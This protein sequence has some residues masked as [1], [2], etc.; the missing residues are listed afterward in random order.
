MVSASVFTVLLLP[1]V[2]VQEDAEKTMERL[3]G[4]VSLS[5]GYKLSTEAPT[6]ALQAGMDSGQPP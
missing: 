3:P 6:Q 5:N 4:A 1:R 2:L